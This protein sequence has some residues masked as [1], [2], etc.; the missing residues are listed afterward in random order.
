MMAFCHPW[1]MPT[2]SLI[3]YHNPGR[4]RAGGPEGLLPDLQCRPIHQHPLKAKQV[5]GVVRGCITITS[6]VGARLLQ[7]CAGGDMLFVFSP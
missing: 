5:S 3:M 2:L 6:K 4:E 7:A 1:H